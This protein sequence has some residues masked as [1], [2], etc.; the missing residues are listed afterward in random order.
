V[1]LINL[2]GRVA[3]A[4][5]LPLVTLD[6]DRLL[7]K[8]IKQAGSSDFGDENFR[9][10]LRRFLASAESEAELTLLGRLMVQG[11]TTADFGIDRERDR[12]PFLLPL[13]AVVATALVTGLF[14]DELDYFY[15]LRVAVGLLVLAWYRRD[16]A[17]GLRHQLRGRNILSWHAVGIG[18]AVYALW[19]GISS[20]AFAAVHQQWIGGFAAGVL[21]AYAQKRRGLLSD[22]IVAHAV[23]NALIAMQVL[24]AG[25][26]SLW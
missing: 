4:L 5:G 25:H 18:V 13:L 1:K 22:A 26:W 16:Y 8:A 12:A 24:F 7:R 6:E 19:I 21:Y 14:V 11:Y 3:K 17:A 20:L 10:G 15:P 23:T 9:E 2:I